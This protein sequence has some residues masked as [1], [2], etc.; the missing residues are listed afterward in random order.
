MIVHVI[1]GQLLNT[2]RTIRLLAFY[3]PD[4]GVKDFMNKL[5]RETAFDSFE[6]RD[7][8]VTAFVKFEISGSLSKEALLAQ[9]ENSR[10]YYAFWEELKPYV[11]GFIKGKTKPEN[12]KLVFSGGEALAKSVHTNA[13]ALFLNMNYENG[14]VHFTTATSQKE[15]ALNKELD[16][17][18][19]EYIE[20]FFRALEI[21]VVHE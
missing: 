10:R 17:R 1:F 2:E 18:W 19:E 20:H 21:N 11:F 14:E 13:A 7:V 16:M 15:F 9:P 6:I 12:I 3:V 5:F 4:T 8:S